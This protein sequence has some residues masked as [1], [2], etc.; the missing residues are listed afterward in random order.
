LFRRRHHHHRRADIGQWGM[1]GAVAAWLREFQRILAPLTE[2][3]STTS[4]SNGSA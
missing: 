4:G 1:A 3:P 2:A